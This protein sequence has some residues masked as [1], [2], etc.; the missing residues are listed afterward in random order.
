MCLLISKQ[1]ARNVSFPSV[2]RIG[3]YSVIIH[4][5]AFTAFHNDLDQVKKFLKPIYVG[6]IERTKQTRDDQIRKDFAELRETAHESGFFQPSVPFF[7]L[8]IGHILIF[9][10]MAYFIM[11]MYGTGWLPYLASVLC[12]TIVQVRPC[13]HSLHFSRA[14]VHSFMRAH[15]IISSKG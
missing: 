12:Y 4:Q 8:N 6:D 13:S 14:I 7:V 2:N 3:I 10:V 11:R 5:E 9:E 1:M 15:N